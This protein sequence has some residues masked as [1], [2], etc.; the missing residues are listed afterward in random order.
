MIASPSAI[1]KNA[2]IFEV[3]DR[4]REERELVSACVQGVFIISKGVS[5]S[6]SAKLRIA[7]VI[8]PRVSIA[9]G[10]QRCMIWC[11]AKYI[12]NTF[13]I[14]LSAA[15]SKT[16]PIAFVCLYLRAIYPST[17][18]RMKM[19]GIVAQAAMSMYRFFRNRAMIV[20]VRQTRV[21]VMILAVI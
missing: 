15:I 11:V 7:S 21:S 20:N 2:N 17:A 13:S 6:F 8:N 12:Q 5:P 19:R 18:S 3:P 9:S 10:I 1:A 14:I 4:N 16:A